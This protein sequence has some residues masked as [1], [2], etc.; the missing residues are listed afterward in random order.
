MN[1]LYIYLCVCVYAKYLN[2]IKLSYLNLNVIVNNNKIE[3]KNLIKFI[4]KYVNI[5]F[6]LYS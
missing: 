5:L 6:K 4:F 1:E 2:I 3:F